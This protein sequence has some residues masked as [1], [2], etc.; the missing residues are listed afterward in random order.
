MIDPNHAT[1]LVFL[2]LVVWREARGE[3][4]EVRLGVAC[5]I[6]N[7]VARPSWWGRD[8]LSV[9]TKKWQY[10]SLTDPKDRQLA[11]WPSPTEDSW[12]KC[13]E[14]A[15]DVLEN[16]VRNPVPGADSYYDV[17]ISPPNWADSARFVG[18]LGRIRF[19]NLDRDTEG[20][21]GGFV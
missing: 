6:M 19:F 3:A 15:S 5:S 12:R 7:R 20:S 2:A 17:S 10:S 16:K 8:V 9:V 13:L 18:Q 1:D 4:C 11:I 21:K 14:L